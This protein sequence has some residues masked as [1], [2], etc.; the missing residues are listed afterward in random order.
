MDFAVVIDI[1][2]NVIIGIGAA[3]MAFGA[4]ALFWLKDFYPRLLVASK[5]D[6]VGLL[7]LLFGVCLRHGFSFFTAKVILIIVIIMIMNPMVSHLTA[8]AAFFSGYQLEG[9][10][11]EE[12]STE[13]DAEDNSDNEEKSE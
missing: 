3:F 9:V 8:R 5:I 7:T 11:T 13:E 4:L 2:A 12:D 1:I 10:L 6:T